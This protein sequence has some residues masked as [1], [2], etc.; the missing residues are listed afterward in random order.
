[1]KR[2]MTALGMMLF[3][4]GPALA[5][6]QDPARIASPD[7][8]IVVEVG[9]EKGKPAYTVSY[10]DRLLLGTS[11]LGFTLDGAPSLA[12]GLKVAEVGRRSF[13]ETWTQP[14]GE[15][16]EIREHY[17]ELTVRYDAAEGPARSLVVTFRLF[18]DGL[19]FRYTIP[20]QP[21]IKD[22]RITDEA[23]EFSFRSNLKTWW[24]PAYGD[25]R[26]EYHFASSPLDAV[27]HPVHTPMTLED[28][29]VAVAIH[30]AAL[31]DFAS[32]TLKRT[33]IHGTALKADL[34]P[35]ADGMKVYGTAP[36]TSPWRTIQ[37]ADKA[38]QLADSHLILNLN[39]PNRLGDVSW[40]KPGKYIGIWWCMHIRTCTWEPGPNQGATT[41]NAKRHIDFAAE[42]GIDGLL[43]EGWNVGWH[44]DW[45][46]DGSGFDFTT[47]VKGFDLEQVAAYAREKGVDL[48]GHHETG[49][50]TKNYERQMEA[51]F[52]LY[53][54]VGVPAV[55]TGYVGVRLD[56][57]EWHHGQYMVR[58]F[59]KVLELAAKH[60][61]AINAHEPIK[62]TGLRRTY[63]NMMSRE[64][65]RGQEYDAW[66]ATDDGNLPEHTTI[67]PFTRMLAGPMDYTPGIFDLRYGEGEENGMSTTLAKQLALYVVIYGPL[68]MAADLPEN[69]Q[70][71]PA[72]KFIKD[73]PADWAESRALDGRIGDY[74][75]FARKD[76]NSRDWYL[77][78]VTD[79]QARDLKVPLDF[80]EKGRRYTA[81][82]YAD[83]KDAH[84]L[85][86]PQPIDIRTR[87]VT[88]A[89]TLD[90][91]LAPG[92][93]QAIRFT[94]A[95]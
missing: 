4:G 41:E 5:Q 82:I 24:I 26:Y 66:G 3:L 79:E 43:I 40:V 65:A 67:L 81:E 52:A 87:T 38:Y 27:L 30:E 17:N 71:Q 85:T 2:L 75:V 29:R 31:V 10:K 64:G 91:K 9:T 56:K 44:T 12:E 45:Y 37:I 42:H 15:E 19:G 51:A 62:D 48:I 32:M 33:A 20:E 46:E 35:W 59:Q 92:G 22:I 73:V 93:G 57:K 58:H 68:Q 50:D 63:P 89:D 80:L 25:N 13:D 6:L 18:D 16:A 14:W 36:M 53:E 11:K 49:A 21:G 74:A 77:G 69:Y 86:N 76:R 55:K 54:R 78:A 94:P 61:I 47:P 72:F 1:M 70:G 34:V 39:E 88:A 83:G 28:D 95:P 60:R 8:R 7:G 84:W 90:V 23:T